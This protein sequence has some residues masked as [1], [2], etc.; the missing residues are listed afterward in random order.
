MTYNLPLEVA[1]RLN[2][3]LHEMLRIARTQRILDHY[4]A[5]ITLGR[6]DPITATDRAV[7]DVNGNNYSPIRPM[8][9][10]ET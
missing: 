2:R 3:N 4:S 6:M 7:G 9:G 5:Q 1:T 8:S 10:G